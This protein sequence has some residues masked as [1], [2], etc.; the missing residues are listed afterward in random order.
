M[1]KSALQNWKDAN[2][3]L[4]G[5]MELLPWLGCWGRELEL[6][7]GDGRVFDWLSKLLRA[8]LVG[9]VTDGDCPL[10]SLFGSRS[11]QRRMLL[12]DPIEMTQKPFDWPLA[13]CSK[14][15][16]SWKSFTPMSWTAF[17]MSWS[18]VHCKTN[19]CTWVT[20]P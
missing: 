10:I 13:R 20:V 15:F 11:M 8:C 18:V 7:V 6:L 9:S 16:T 17:A 1:F 19:H 12:S 5:W 4:P 14:N 3:S 2:T